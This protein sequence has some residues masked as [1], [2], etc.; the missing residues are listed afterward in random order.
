MTTY[1]SLGESYYI[2]PSCIFT[3]NI[4]FSLEVYNSLNYFSY[5]LSCLFIIP[6]TSPQLYPNLPKFILKCEF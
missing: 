1:Q 6:I 3:N 5:G 2:Q 4:L